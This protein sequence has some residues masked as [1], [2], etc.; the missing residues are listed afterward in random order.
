MVLGRTLLPMRNRVL[1]S[2]LVAVFALG[3]VAPSFGD[4]KG[5][6]NANA[7]GYWTEERKNNAVSREFQFEVG[8]TEGKLVT[9][10][11]RGSSGGNVNFP[12]GTTEKWIDVTKKEAEITGKVF[13]TMAGTDYVCSGSLIRD[14]SDTFD[15]VVTAGHCVWNNSKVPNQRGF[16]TNW[17]FYP[18]FASTAKTTNGLSARVLVAHPNFT[19]QT[20]FNTTATLYDFAF[21]VVNLSNI[22]DLEKPSVVKSDDTTFPGTVGN[23]FG[24]PAVGYTGNDLW[25]SKGNVITDPNNG[26]RTWRIPSDMTGGAS[27]GPWYS[28]YSS[29]SLGNNASVNSYK[30]ASDSKGMYGPKFNQ[31]TF[32]LLDQAQKG[33]CS[34][35]VLTKVNCKSY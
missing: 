21:A 26:N 34:G 3:V 22:A 31:S 20:S 9:Q 2:A 1:T 23:A 27:G 6:P 24:Y 14:N 7:S 12:S 17:T 5:V 33:S 18:N 25:W 16:A 10:A 4:A 32:D 13:F 15:I 35:A 11:K 19:S 28:N 8:A 29:S 30:Y